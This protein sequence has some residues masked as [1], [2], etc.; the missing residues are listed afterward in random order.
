[1]SPSSGH[2]ERKKS[3]LENLGQARGKS[4]YKAVV[5]DAEDNTGK[6]GKHFSPI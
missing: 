3:V 6:G 2:S 4:F 1:M 5:G